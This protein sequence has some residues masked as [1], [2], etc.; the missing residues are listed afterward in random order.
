M[1]MRFSRQTPMALKG[2]NIPMPTMR[3]AGTT[4]LGVNQ[5]FK[6]FG[7]VS[8][9][10]AMTQD[11][12]KKGDGSAIVHE[13][14]VQADAPKRGGADFVCAVMEFGERE[15]SPADLVHVLAVM[16]GHGLDDAVAGAD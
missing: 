2:P 8:G 11:G 7:D 4:H 12:I 16:L 6:F 15:V 9:L 13:A 14:R 5:L 10:A 1:S 3:T